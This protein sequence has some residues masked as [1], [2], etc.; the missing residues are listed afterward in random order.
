[1]LIL[2]FFSIE[3]INVELSRSVLSRFDMS[4]DIFKHYVSTD[5]L[6]YKFV[7]CQTVKFTNVI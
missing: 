7:V 3:F 4:K 2:F 5:L 1:M 6:N